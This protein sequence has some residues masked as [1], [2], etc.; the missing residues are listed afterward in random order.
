MPVISGADNLCKKHNPDRI[1]STRVF[2]FIA[3]KIQ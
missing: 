2:V 1:N 3:G